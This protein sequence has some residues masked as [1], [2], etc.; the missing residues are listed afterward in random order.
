MANNF[1]SGQ[2]TV[3]VSG[4]RGSGKTFMVDSIMEK[5]IELYGEG[6]I[7]VLDKP[8][9]DFDYRLEKAK[10]KKILIICEVK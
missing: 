2:I 8:S 7:E 3:S 10:D 4:K 9:P 5:L 6:E 1:P